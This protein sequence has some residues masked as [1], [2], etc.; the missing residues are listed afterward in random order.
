MNLDEDPEVVADL[1]LRASSERDPSRSRPSEK[2]LGTWKPDEDKFVGAWKCRYFERAKC[3]EFVGVTQDTVDRLE[4]F[5]RML[6]RR[7]EAPINTSTVLICDRCIARRAESVPAKLRARVDEL[8]GVIR[9]IKATANPR[10]EHDLIRELTRLS[11]PDVKGLL[12]ALDGK[13]KRDKSRPRGD[14]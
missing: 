6:D 2:L 9:K 8:A 4:Q 3:G 5:N 11:H 14:L 13:L 10:A 1:R 7:G 12:D